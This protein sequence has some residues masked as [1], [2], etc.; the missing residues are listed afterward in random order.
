MNMFEE[1]KIEAYFFFHIREKFTKTE[2]V[3]PWFAEAQTFCS[4][5]LKS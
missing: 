4:V 5:I 3:G 1:T 2:T